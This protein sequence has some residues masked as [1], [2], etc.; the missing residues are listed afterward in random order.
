[1]EQSPAAVGVRKDKTTRLYE[2]LTDGRV[3]G[4]LAYETT[5]GRSCPTT[6]T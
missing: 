2:A 6:L 5:G 3:V 1:M 4:K